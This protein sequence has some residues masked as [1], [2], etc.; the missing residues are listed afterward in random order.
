MNGNE[1][2]ARVC[3][4]IRKDGLDP[5]LATVL[6]FVTWEEIVRCV[7]TSAGEAGVLEIEWPE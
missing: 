1:A 7:I 3:D 5:D 2:V 6:S 4:Q